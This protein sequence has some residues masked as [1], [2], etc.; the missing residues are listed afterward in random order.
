M[1]SVG[2]AHLILRPFYIQYFVQRRLTSK[3]ENSQHIIKSKGYFT[4][5]QQPYTITCLELS[6]RSEMLHL[7]KG[8]T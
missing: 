1:L 7:Y 3:T 4:H 2:Y 6:G 8:L 5:S